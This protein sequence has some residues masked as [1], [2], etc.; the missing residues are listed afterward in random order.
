MSTLPRLLALA[1]VANW[2]RLPTR[3]VAKMARGREIPAVELPGGELV[4]DAGDLAGWLE[5]RKATA[6]ETR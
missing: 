1:D 6:Q 4:F 2:L 5:S 3:K